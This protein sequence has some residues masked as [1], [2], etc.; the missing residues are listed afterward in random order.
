MF[1]R[2]QAQS[3]LQMWLSLPVVYVLSYL[4]WRWV[5]RPLMQSRDKVRKGEPLPSFLAV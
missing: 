1:P 3:N 4:I 5:E 2:V